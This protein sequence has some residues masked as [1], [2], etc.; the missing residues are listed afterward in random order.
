MDHV[1][2]FRWVER[3]TP[4]LIDTARYL[5]RGR[6]VAAPGCWDR[7]NLLPLSLMIRGCCHRSWWCRWIADRDMACEPAG[8]FV[9][10]LP[11]AEAMLAR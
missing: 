2:L 8:L 9:T 3:F 5:V 7:H 11:D 4:E 6:R 1:T 10:W